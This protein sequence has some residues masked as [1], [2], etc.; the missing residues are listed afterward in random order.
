MSNHIHKTQKINKYF[1]NNLQGLQTLRVLI[2]HESKLTAQKK[3]IEK[4]NLRTPPHLSDNLLQKMLTIKNQ[5]S[6]A[7]TKT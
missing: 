7:P 4:V 3:V 6:L 2:Q 1:N 5:E